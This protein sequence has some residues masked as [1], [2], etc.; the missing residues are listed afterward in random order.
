[1]VLK[2]EKA[3]ALLWPASRVDLTSPVRLFAAGAL[4]AL[5]LTL[6]TAQAGAQEMTPSETPS[7]TAEVSP[8]TTVEP[9]ASPTGDES[10][11]ATPTGDASPSASPTGEESPSASPTSEESPSVSPTSE[12]SPSASATPDATPSGTPVVTATPTEEEEP[13]ARLGRA[14]DDL[15][16]D[17]GDRMSDETRGLAADVRHELESLTGFAAAVSMGTMQPGSH[18]K[19]EFRELTKSLQQK[20]N[21]LRHSVQDDVHGMAKGGGGHLVSDIR[22]D[23]SAVKLSVKVAVKEE[24]RQLK[25]VLK[26]DPSAPQDSSP[27]ATGTP[28]ASPT[29]EP[30][31]SPTAEASPTESPEASPTGV[32]LASVSRDT[33]ERGK[34]RKPSKQLP[35]VAVPQVA[36]APVA[37]VVRVAQP[38]TLPARAEEKKADE[39]KGKGPAEAKKAAAPPTAPA[40][41]ASPKPPKAE[42]PK[43]AKVEAPKQEAKPA[44]AE[45]R[46]EPPK[47]NNPASG[48]SGKKK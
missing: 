19:H 26:H 36:L 7:A 5:G 15:E 9:S 14:L 4:I 40:K 37:P 47:A 6:S 10:P 33:D 41:A 43:P 31:V 39:A 22:H 24:Q 20:L 44:K 34:D 32:S 38:P 29:V 16:A 28:D 25:A 17:L 27:T 3:G 42:A 12:A 2:A 13:L 35:P 8:S 48:N 30:S 23:L 11:S 1:M 18:L 46:P 21:A 45:A